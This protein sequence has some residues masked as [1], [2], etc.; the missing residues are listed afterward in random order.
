MYKLSQY[1]LK[2]IVPV[3]ANVK[4]CIGYLTLYFYA[5]VGYSSVN[6]ARS[7]LSSILKPENE[8]SFGV[9]PF[10]CRLLKGIFNLGPFLPRYTT[11]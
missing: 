5:E 6:T 4:I 7:V 8:T 9:D 11:T 3:Q 1:F 2:K 10:V